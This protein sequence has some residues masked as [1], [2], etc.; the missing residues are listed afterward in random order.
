MLELTKFLGPLVPIFNKSISP[1]DQYQIVVIVGQ[2]FPPISLKANEAMGFPAFDGSS[3]RWHQAMGWENQ[4]ENPI[5]VS[6]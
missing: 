6:R 4:G 1:Y 2:I 5:Q 3:N